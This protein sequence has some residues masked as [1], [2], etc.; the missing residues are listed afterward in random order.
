M[1]YDHYQGK[2]LLPLLLALLTGLLWV[3]LEVIGVP[4]PLPSLLALVASVLLWIWF[5]LWLWRY[6]P[7]PE[8]N[9]ARVRTFQIGMTLLSLAMLS[10]Y[11]FGWFAVVVFNRTVP[12]ALGALWFGILI[13]SLLGS[14][15]MIWRDYRLQREEASQR[16]EH[17]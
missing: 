10:I 8:E 13:P 9:P 5:Y 7:V 4:G 15:L 6:Q 2:I 16:A 14:V 1:T 12:F 3:I 11:T 17:S